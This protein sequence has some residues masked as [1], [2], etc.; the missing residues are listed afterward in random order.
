M[1]TRNLPL[2][3]HLIRVMPAK[4]GKL[5]SSGSTA[6]SPAGTLAVVGGGVIGISVARRA[7]SGFHGS[8]KCEI[9]ILRMRAMLRSLAS[10]KAR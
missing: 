2:P 9:I 10:S 8:G 5:M 4:G 1:G 3:S 6:G 7:L